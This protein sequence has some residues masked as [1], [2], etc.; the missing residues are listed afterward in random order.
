MGGEAL[1]LGPTVGLELF[2]AFCPGS[3]TLGKLPHL[4]ELH[5]GDRGVSVVNVRH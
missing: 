5:W 2:V 4:S 3:V 1:A